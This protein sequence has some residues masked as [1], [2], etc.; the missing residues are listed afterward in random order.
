MKKIII[1]IL[2]LCCFTVSLTGCGNEGNSNKN[3]ND[4]KANIMDSETENSS[5]ESYFI[6]INN[7]KIEFPCKLKKFTDIG[8]TLNSNDEILL[9]NSSAE[10]EMVNLE[11]NGL[12]IIHVFIKPGKDDM[13]NLTVIGFSIPSYV[14]DGFDIEFNGLIQGQ[15]TLEDVLSEFGNP[16]IPE[17]IDKTQYINALSY[18]GGKLIVSTEDNKFSSAQY[19]GT[20]EEK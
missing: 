6:K 19:I 7:K 2:V 15:S 4:Q 1:G 16:E 10:Y 17:Q 9:Q 5:K 14:S 12:P 3:N 13:T 11:S 18:K 8:L 20:E